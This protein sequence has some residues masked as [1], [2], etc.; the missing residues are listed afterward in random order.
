MRWK[1]AV[2][3]LEISSLFWKNFK[4]GNPLLVTWC[5]VSDWIGQEH[6]RLSHLFLMSDPAALQSYIVMLHLCYFS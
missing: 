2:Y 1:F 4:C 5:A 6:V 3:F